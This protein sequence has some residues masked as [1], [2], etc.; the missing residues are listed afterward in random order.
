MLCP[1]CNA[2]NIQGARFCAKCGSI[3]E[4]EGPP[5]EADPLIGT[6]VGG[7][8]TIE[9]MLGEGGMGR[10]YEAVRHIA[11]VKQRV[12][13]KTLH[14]HLSAD[15]QIVARFHRE[16]GT[17]AQLRHPNTIKVEDFGQT[18]DGTLYI[19]MEFVDGR[20]VAD[21]LEKNGPMSPER[22]EHVLEQVCGSLAEAH[23]QGV[24]HRDLKPENVVLMDVGD[25]VDFVKVLDFGIA[26][27][28]DSTDAAKEAKL[29]QQGMV[30]GT[31]PYMSPEQFMGKELD[32]RSDIYSLGV[33]AYEML[34]GKLPFSA[35]TPWEWATCHMTA[36]P[37]PFEDSPT[38]TD[39]PGKMKT[40]IFR[41]LSKKPE[42]RQSTV[43]EFFEELSSGNARLRTGTMTPHEGVGGAEAPVSGGTQRTEMGLPATPSFE[44]PAPYHQHPGQASV[45]PGMGPAAAYVPPPPAPMAYGGG[46]GS[47]AKSGSNTGLIAAA[48]VV[49]LIVVGALVMIVVKMNKPEGDPSVTLTVPS[50]GFTAATAAPPT[51]LSVPAVTASAAP[52]TT[53]VAVHTATPVATPAPVSG[54]AACAEAKR[55]ATSR[56]IPGAVSTMSRCS[57]SSRNDAAASIKANT[58]GAAISAARNNDCAS[59]RRIAS[60]G[61]NYGAGM[62]VD[63]DPETSKLCKGK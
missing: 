53:A 2:E 23:K 43:R 34:T 45:V 37:S 57:G 29:T 33:M 51:T 24:V 14:P 5:P 42:D 59:A 9:R 55:Q 11:G 30:L 16:C 46:G 1:S 25:D 35:N 52:T 6:T 10:V 39:I 21:H 48:V 8:Y 44:P 12:A 41:A 19:A 7:R 13:I 47:A 20:T 38:M 26:A 4:S 61:N 40:A 22:S 56:N 28:K 15:A 49:G 3:L 63:S 18:A 62:N 31:P 50:G 58:R 60:A 27:R 17:V 32:S 36:Q 54:D